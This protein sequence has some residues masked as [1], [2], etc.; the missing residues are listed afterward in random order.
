MSNPRRVEIPISEEL[1]K[2]ARV[3]RS[4]IEAFIESVNSKTEEAK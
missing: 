2:D 1:L 3:W 4:V